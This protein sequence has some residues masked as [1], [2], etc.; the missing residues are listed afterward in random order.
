[1]PFNVN[2]AANEFIGNAEIERRQTIRTQS[3]RPQATQAERQ[4]KFDQFL[5]KRQERHVEAKKQ[6]FK[7][8]GRTVNETTARGFKAI[9][10]GVSR[11]LRRSKGAEKYKPETRHNAAIQRVAAFNARF[12]RE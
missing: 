2:N 5:N 8:A 4:Q 1:M 11:L 3:T 7:E 6:S 12:K 9:D 10:R